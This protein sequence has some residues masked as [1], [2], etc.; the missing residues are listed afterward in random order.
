MTLPKI[1]LPLY[2]LKLPSS[3]KIVTVRPFLVKEEKLLLMAVESQDER[4]IINVTKQ[5]INNCLIN[6]D[7]DIDKLPFFDVDYLFIALRAKSV[8]EDIEVKFSCNNIHEDKRCGFVFPAKIDISNCKIVKNDNIPSSINIGK[9]YIV[10][11]KYP[12]YTTMRVLLEDGMDAEK[13]IYLIAECIDSIVTG[14]TVYTTKDKTKE[15]MVEFV[16]GL[17]Q[18][19][20]NLLETFVDNFPTFVVTSKAKCSK[21]GFDHELEYREFTSFFV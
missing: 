2:D 19:Q 5:V 21:C 15:E 9:G 17:T 16:E 11:M 6:S 3:G 12:N 13:K 10:K 20:F 1:D 4:E 8:G 14:D 18:Q 7:I